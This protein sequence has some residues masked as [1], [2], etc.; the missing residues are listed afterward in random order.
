MRHFSSSTLNTFFPPPGLGGRSRVEVL[1]SIS[2]IDSYRTTIPGHTCAFQTIIPFSPRSLRI[3]DYLRSHFTNPAPVVPAVFDFTSAPPAGPY[4]N[5]GE[6]SVTS[7]HLSSS[8]PEHGTL[9]DRYRGVTPQS[10]PPDAPPCTPP[11]APFHAHRTALSCL[12]RRG[13]ESIGQTGRLR[14][15]KRRPS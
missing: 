12:N 4:P 9:L 2:K 1:A 6:R 11:H 13:D 3:P 10:S 5:L 8:E 15:S 7:R 14:L